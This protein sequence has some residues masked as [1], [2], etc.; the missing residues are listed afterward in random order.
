MLYIQKK[1]CTLILFFKD[2]YYLK[3]FKFSN[4]IIGKI[5][6]YIIRRKK[7]LKKPIQKTKQRK[8]NVFLFFN[9]IK[10]SKKCYKKI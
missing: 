5:K 1:N 6:T 7:K 2:Y 8:I 3:N 4:L 9:N 10:S